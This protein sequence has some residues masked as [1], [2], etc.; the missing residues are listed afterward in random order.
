MNDEQAFMSKDYEEIQKWISLQSKEVRDNSLIV[1]CVNLK[2]NFMLHIDKETPKVFV[3]MMPRS[4]SLTENNTAARITVAPNLVGCFIGYARAE[5]DFLA[6]S[7]SDV[8]KSTQFKGGY[9]ICSLPFTHAIFPAPKL[10]YD[11]KRSNEHWLVTYNQQTLEYVPEK[12]GKLFVSKVTYLAETGKLPSPEFEIYIEV[13]KPSGILFSP[14][15][16]LKAGYHKT[17]VSFERKK[18]PG[19]TNEED[20]FEVTEISKQEYDK[21]KKLS[22]AMLSRDDTAPHFLKW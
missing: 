4:A 6:G 15:I 17:V 20:N 21:V 14:S 16:H 9:S 12:I 7:A 10:V 22:A 8:I 18:H 3:P 19:S 11:S 13:N 1:D 2:Q 5:T